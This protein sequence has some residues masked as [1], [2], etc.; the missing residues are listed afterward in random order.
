MMI[1]KRS[2]V[3][4]ILFGL[5]TAGIYWL[6]WYY[7]LAKDV[8]AMCEGDGKETAGLLK[9][10]LLS[11]VTFGIYFYI[12]LFMLGD[13]LQDAAPKYD[14][15]IKESGSTLLLWWLLGVVIVVGPYIAVYLIIR[16]TNAM[17]ENYN[18]KI[19]FAG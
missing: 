4:Y 3:R 2:I 15:T 9:L 16:N 13:R 6:Y 10:M 5:L 18:K 11:L 19:G 8:N 14:I 7:K 17:V 12:W 1:E